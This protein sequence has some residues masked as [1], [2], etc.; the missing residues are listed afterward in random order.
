MAP[1]TGLLFGTKTGLSFG[2]QNQ[3]P[4]AGL[5]SHPQ[6]QSIEK[7]EVDIPI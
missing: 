6:N 3:P 1:Q 5:F 4:Q 2:T 7:P